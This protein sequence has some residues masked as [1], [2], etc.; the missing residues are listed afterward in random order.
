MIDCLKYSQVSVNQ[1]CS[2]CKVLG[3][4]WHS[5]L[6]FEL[7]LKTCILISTNNEMHKMKF[8]EITHLAVK[9]HKILRAGYNCEILTTKITS[10]CQCGYPYSLVYSLKCWC[11]ARCLIILTKIYSRIVNEG[12]RQ[13]CFASYYMHGFVGYSCCHLNILPRR[14]Y[15][16][17]T[18]DLHCS[19]LVRHIR[20]PQKSEQNPDSALVIGY[21]GLIHARTPTI[22]NKMG[23][24]I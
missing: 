18:I 14:Y 6:V 15:E 19:L 10:Y 8:K 4:P 24:M 5:S 2:G 23:L 12:Q 11:Q 16:S 7:V 1:S 22:S 17:V 13:R 20:S 21:H 3:E 9:Q